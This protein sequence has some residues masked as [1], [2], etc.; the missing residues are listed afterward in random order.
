MDPI[1][2]FKLAK[3][4]LEAKKKENEFKRNVFKVIEK[5]LKLRSLGYDNKKLERTLKEMNL[6]IRYHLFI[7]GNFT[8]LMNRT[9]KIYS[10]TI[11]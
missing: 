9:H 8:S 4:E 10:R 7:L 2:I 11:K 3:P 6:P 5:L 1:D